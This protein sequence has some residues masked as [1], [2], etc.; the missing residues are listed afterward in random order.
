[1]KNYG[2]FVFFLLT[3]IAG[4]HIYW[5]FGG[6]WPG[7]TSRELIDMVIGSSVMTEMPPMPITLFVAILIFISGLLALALSG[8]LN[9][10]PRWLALTL[11]FF[12]SL[13]F[14]ARG[15]AGYGA[16]RLGISRTEIFATYDMWLYSPICL[17]IGSIMLALFI[18][19]RV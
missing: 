7:T 19:K 3:A 6:L 9:P 5:S 17:L 15:L 14:L 12:A 16:D 18:H 4:L 10:S 13:V 2:Y 11:G 8:V 1:M